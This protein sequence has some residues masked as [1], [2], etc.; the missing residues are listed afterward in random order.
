[1]LAKCLPSSSRKLL[2]RSLAHTC[3]GC[4]EQH[5]FVTRG[6]SSNGKSTCS[7]PV[8]AS[9]NPPSPPP[10]RTIPCCYVLEGDHVLYN[11]PHLRC[12]WRSRAET[13]PTRTAAPHGKRDAR[14]LP[15]RPR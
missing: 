8:S 4:P 15:R 14:F 6:L 5:C 2:R 7:S 13:P 9:K 10:A 11:P 12:R 3:K 1:M